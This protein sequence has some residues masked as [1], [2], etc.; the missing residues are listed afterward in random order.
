MPSKV[1]MLPQNTQLNFLIIN[2]HIFVE[3]SNIMFSLRFY[4][5]LEE[6]RQGPPGVPGIYIHKLSTDFLVPSVNHFVESF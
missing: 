6:G 1:F 3:L 4:S 2:L 5:G